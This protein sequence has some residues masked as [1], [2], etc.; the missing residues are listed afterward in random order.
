MDFFPPR[1]PLARA[2]LV[3]KF[4]NVTPTKVNYETDTTTERRFV[5]LVPG[6]TTL[7]AARGDQSLVRFSVRGI[8]PPHGAV[9]RLGAGLGPLLGQ[10]QPDCQSRTAWHEARGAQVF[11][12]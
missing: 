5:E 2:K 6:R 10:R 4:S 1:F 9:Q 3:R 12:S 11:W 8:D 7:H